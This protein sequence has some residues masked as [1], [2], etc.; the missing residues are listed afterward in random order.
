MIGGSFATHPGGDNMTYTVNIKFDSDTVIS[1][2][3]DFEVSS[4][5]YYLHVDPV[6]KVLATTEFFNPE[7]NP[8]TS[9]KYTDI[10]VVWT[11]MW[12]KGRV[13]YT[14]LGHCDK[15]FDIQEAGEILRRGL[16]WAGGK[17]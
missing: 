11:K 8:Y 1:D 16:L 10:P 6:V 12:G 7:N 3:D 15:I 17:M 4:E 13:F 9:T 2:I 5:Q 14:S